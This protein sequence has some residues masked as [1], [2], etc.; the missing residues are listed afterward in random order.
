MK[1]TNLIFLVLIYV[2]LLSMCSCVSRKVNIDKSKEE[3]KI[4]LTDN[5]VIEKQTESNVKTETKTTVYDKNE[6]VTEET[7]YTPQDNT[8]ESFVIEKDGTKVVLN[9]TQ[10]TYKKT[11]QN[12]NTKTENA[13]HVDSV[14]KE[15]SKERKAVKRVN[16]SKKQK[17]DLEKKPEPF[18]W[19][20]LLWFLI[21]ILIIYIAYR[22]YKQLTLFPKF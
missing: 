13:K 1:K 17:L 3:T 2:L 22:K 11:T 21:P 4:E 10:K 20:N 18:N 14:K 8:K 5:S 7:I 6:T 16:S 15:A 19:F 12:N 9:N